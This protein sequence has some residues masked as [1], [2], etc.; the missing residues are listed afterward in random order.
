MGNPIAY[1]IDEHAA[2]RDSVRLLDG[3]GI[4]IGL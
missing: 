4:E 2:F 3:A 1:V